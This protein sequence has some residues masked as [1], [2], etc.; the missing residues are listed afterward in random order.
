MALQAGGFRLPLKTGWISFAIAM[1]LFDRVAI[2][3]FHLPFFPVDINL[4]SLNSSEIFHSHPTTMTAIARLVHRRA[5]KKLVSSKETTS[6][7]S[8]PEI[9]Q[10][11]QDA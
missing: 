6:S 1:K 5:F 9:W 2:K 4:I 8:L 7:R 3:A 10:P 11:P